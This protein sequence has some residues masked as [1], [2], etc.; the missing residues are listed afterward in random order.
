M[1]P[2]KC[3]HTS[4]RNERCLAVVFGVPIA[5]EMS[6]VS[7]ER[8]KRFNSAAFR[9]NRF[10]SDKEFTHDRAYTHRERESTI[11]TSTNVQT[12]EQHIL[13][14]AARRRKYGDGD[15]ERLASEPD[16]GRRIPSRGE[17]GMALI[18]DSS[19]LSSSR[20]SMIGM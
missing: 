2:S 14:V 19:R 4:S 13:G 16:R 15:G 7:V 1:L 6:T 17:P 20:S 10:G 8:R 5:L 12:K 11:R 3:C 18:G 9:D